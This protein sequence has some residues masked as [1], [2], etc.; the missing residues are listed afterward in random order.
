MGAEIE[1]KF[2]VRDDSWKAGAEGKAFRQGYICNKPEASVRVRISGRKAFLTIKG[3]TRGMR[4]AE[5][6]YPVPLEDA[7]ELLDTLCEKPIIEKT[8]YLIPH[9]GGTWELDVF[10]GE[11]DGLVVAEIELPSEDAQFSRPAWL[12]EEVTSDA[13][14]Y[15][16]NLV[17]NPYSKWKK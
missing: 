5:F 17:S 9:E 7:A 1:R 4:R 3:E 13:R 6:E 10:H 11:N 2:L 8:R 16:V 14:Y 12:G 15:N